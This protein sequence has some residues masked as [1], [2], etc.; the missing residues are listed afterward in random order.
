MS[1][2]KRLLKLNTFSIIQILSKWVYFYLWFTQYVAIFGGGF[3]GRHIGEE[4]TVVVTDTSSGVFGESESF[5]IVDGTNFQEV[6]GG[7]GA[8][9][10]MNL[11]MVLV[12][13]ICGKKIDFNFCIQISV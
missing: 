4:F 12:A 6:G 8:V 5:E 2:L 7:G 10:N 3:G 13:S 1:L 9:G 11:A